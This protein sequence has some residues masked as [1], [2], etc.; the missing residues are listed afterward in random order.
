M[1]EHT[2]YLAAT[3]CAT[4][5]QLEE[6]KLVTNG[7]LSSDPHCGEQATKQMNKH[8]LCVYSNRWLIVGVLDACRNPVVAVH[9][10]PK[11]AVPGSFGTSNS[12]TQLT[13]IYWHA[14]MRMHFT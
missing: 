5:F 13:S 2:A 1:Q 9:Y 14:Y 4:W 8:V 12:A 11:H 10:K 7:S 6:P 3:L